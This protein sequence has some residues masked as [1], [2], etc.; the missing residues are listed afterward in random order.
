MGELLL[1]R[2]WQGAACK[3]PAAC[4][5]CGNG[6]HCCCCCSSLGASDS[7]QPGPNCCSAAA[8]VLLR[9]AEV[10]LAREGALCFSLPPLLLLLLKVLLLLGL[11]KGVLLPALLPASGFPPLPA[12]TI[13]PAGAV[14][15]ALGWQK[16]PRTS[17]D[18]TPRLLLRC[19]A[20]REW[21][22]PTP[23]SLTLPAELLPPVLL[24]WRLLLP[25]WLSY[26]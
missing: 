6:I 18:S 23:P 1:L 11:L 7:T 25:F 3:Q 4:G 22:A 5:N 13:P 10:L 2:W 19:I 24:P 9:N 20:D 26:A 15:A 8:A 17:C 12:P 21:P 14:G 16:C